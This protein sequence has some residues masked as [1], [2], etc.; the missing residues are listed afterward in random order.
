MK[1]A[2]GSSGNPSVRAW[3]P[4]SVLVSAHLLRHIR[5]AQPD[6]RPRRADRDTHPSPYSARHAWKKNIMKKSLSWRLFIF[7]AGTLFALLAG[8]GASA[9]AVASPVQVA[10]NGNYHGDDARLSLD[11]NW[12]GDLTVRG[13]NYDSQRVYV[14]IV[15][16]RYHGDGRTIDDRNVWT[17]RGDFKFTSDEGKCGNYYQAYSYSHKDGRESS[18]V[19]KLNCDDHGH[20][21]R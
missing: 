9:P 1:I 11:T 2:T 14:K 6:N 8:L 15:E 10:A 21:R 3:L 17:D 4:E 12:N 18:E 7:V 20:H 5:A 13:D 16:V 19:V